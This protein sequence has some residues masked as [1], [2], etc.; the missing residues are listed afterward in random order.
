LGGVEKFLWKIKNVEGAS[1]E[2]R[3]CGRE[4]AGAGK[5]KSRCTKTQGSEYIR[6][7]T[8]VSFYVREYVLMDYE[9]LRVMGLQGGKNVLELYSDRRFNYR[10]IQMRSY[11]I[12]GPSGGQ[13]EK[14]PKFRQQ[15]RTRFKGW[16][17]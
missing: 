15:E 8:W 16:H 17:R 14:G 5:N 3:V 10:I 12:S 2:D 1:S 4:N 6:V 9:G 7:D 11:G 13:G